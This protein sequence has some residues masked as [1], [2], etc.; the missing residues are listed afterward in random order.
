MNDYYLLGRENKKEFACADGGEQGAEGSSELNFELHLVKLTISKNG[1]AISDDLS[2]LSTTWLDFQ[3][4]NL[5]LPLMSNRL[6]EFITE[7]LTGDE[8]LYWILAKINGPGGVRNYYI[9]VFEREL[10]VL[11]TENTIYSEDGSILTPHFSLN[12]VHQLGI[13]HC[14]G[15]G[16]SLKIASALYVNEM[17]KR[18]VQKNRLTGMTFKKVNVI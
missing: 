8:G 9:P 3:P 2:G 12:K 1:T 4:N 10:D 7:N 15:E 6:K 11:D 5:E 18:A 13:F 14:P 16:G 17:V